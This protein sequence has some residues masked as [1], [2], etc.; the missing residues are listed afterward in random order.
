M[1]HVLATVLIKEGHLPEALDCY[2]YLVPQVLEKEP[3]CLEYIPTVDHDLGLANQD[4]APTRILVA[5]RWQ[6]ETDFRAH[7]AMPHCAEFRAR[8]APYLAERI[9]VSITR[10]ALEMP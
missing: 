2:R 6:S 3:G 1:I 5:E 7:L 9:S 8:I 4:R 10:P